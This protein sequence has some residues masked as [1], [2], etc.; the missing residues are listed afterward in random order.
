MPPNH[1]RSKDGVAPIGG[2]PTPRANT[3]NEERMKRTIIIK[4]FLPF[5]RARIP[6]GD[7]GSVHTDTWSEVPAVE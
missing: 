3:Q 6:G 2:R 7:G 1:D 5:G 4:V